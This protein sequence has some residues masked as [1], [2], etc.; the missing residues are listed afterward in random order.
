[1]ERWQRNVIGGNGGRVLGVIAG[2]LALGSV[3][4]GSDHQSKNIRDNDVIDR[5][6]PLDPIDVPEECTVTANCEDGDRCTENRCIAR[7][8]VAIPIPSEECCQATT[9][10]EE[11][12]DDTLDPGLTLSQLNDEAGWSV[13]DDATTPS[14]PNALYF[15]DPLTHSYDKGMQVAGSVTLPP[16]ELPSDKE[17]V[18]SFRLYA[19]IEPTIE[20]DLFWVEADVTHDTSATETLTLFTK[21]DLP[22]TAYQDFAL[23]D[24]PLKDLAG[25]TVTLRLRFDTL[26]GNSNAF[27]GVYVDDL[28]VQT[29][30]PIPPPC[31]TDEECAVDDAC[32]ASAC[33]PIGCVE[34]NTCTEEPNPCDAEGAPE[35]C[36]VA[37][38]DCDDGDPT[39]LDVCDGATCAHAPNPDACLDSLGCDDQEVCT[40]DVCDAATATC[41]HIGLIGPDCCVPG[42]NRLADFDD[43]SLQGLYVTDNFETGVFWRA[44]RTRST[45][46]EF[47]LYCG[48]PID[49]TYGIGTRVKSSA[50]TRPLAIPK[51]GTTTVELDLYKQTRSLRNWDVFQVFALRD[52]ALFPV[53]TSRDREDGTAADLWQHLS[54]SLAEYAGTTVQLRFVFDSVDALNAPFEGVYIDTIELVTKCQ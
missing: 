33:S 36:C 26:D 54:V 52:G 5:D 38:A 40:V 31:T 30:C 51:G 44:D 16:I 21:R 23:I 10:F 6:S 22:I 9:L 29:L 45:S 46:G 15:G 8:C 50:T 25:Q 43:E 14:P 7:A 48:D 17:A 12:F 37:D 18:V 1:M 3:A 35:D 39:T 42:D 28:K 47:G 41:S 24:V 32:I 11:D 53:W 49:Q 20:Y 27:E 19:P 2:A 4:C 13:I 34:T